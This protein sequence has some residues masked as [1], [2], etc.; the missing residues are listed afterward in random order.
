MKYIFLFTTICCGACFAQN[1]NLVHVVEYKA[2]EYGDVIPYSKQRKGKSALIL[3]PG[4]GF[5]APVFSDF[6]Q[7]NRKNY[8]MFPVTIPGYGNSAAPPMPDSAN[9]SYGRQHW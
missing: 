6:V 4:M 7:R 8:T 3:V 5:D 9:A 1:N 2:S